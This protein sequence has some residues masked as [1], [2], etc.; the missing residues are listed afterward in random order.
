ML[1][2]VYFVTAALV[3]LVILAS[4]GTGSNHLIDLHLAST[5]VIGVSL[6]RGEISRRVV[7]LTYA[8]LAAVLAAISWPVPGVPSVMATLFTN[9]PRQRTRVEEVRA[10]FLPPS[11]VYLSTDPW[12]RC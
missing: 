7:T 4:P 6:H 9:G 1:A 12:C 10:Q 3:T 2:H 11:T 8:I 5:L